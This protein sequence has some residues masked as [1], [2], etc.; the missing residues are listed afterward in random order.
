MT[1]CC[2]GSKT[3][4]KQTHV[5]K[6]AYHADKVPKEAGLVSKLNSVNPNTLCDRSKPNPRFMSSW[7]GCGVDHGNL[8]LLS[9]SKPASSHLSPSGILRVRRYSSPH[10]VCCHNCVEEPAL[11]TRLDFV[12]AWRIFD[13]QRLQN[14][15]QCRVVG[16]LGWQMSPRL[17]FLEF[18]WLPV[19]V[20]PSF[21]LLWRLRRHPVHRHEPSQCG[22][23]PEKI[24]NSDAA[25][26]F[27]EPTANQ[28]SDF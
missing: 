26:Q 13:V 24:S 3:K 12:R 14:L 8:Q 9:Y 27:E 7:I 1:C 18:P 4:G 19:G 5:Q 10:L 2:I 28:I 15:R 25:S 11:P 6:P 16:N 21:L 23:S 20:T 17:P 22:C